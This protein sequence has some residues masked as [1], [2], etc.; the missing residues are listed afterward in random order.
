MTAEHHHPSLG[1]SLFG[2][3]PHRSPAPLATTA[4]IGVLLVCAA[5]VVL[6][7]ISTDQARL[8]HDYLTGAAALRDLYDMDDYANSW[9]WP[10]WAVQIATGLVFLGWLRRARTNA[11]WLAGPDSQHLSRGWTIGGWFCPVVNLWFPHR[12]VADIW[13][14]SAP[15][16]P[17]RATL[18]LPWWLIFVAAAV[19]NI[20]STRER[21]TVRYITVRAEVEQTLRTIATLDTVR[22]GLYGA[23]GLLIILIIARITHWQNTPRDTAEPT[24]HVVR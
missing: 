2:Q 5:Q 10:L 15:H 12:V 6:A 21:I 13:R 22:A 14:A 7:T 18:V 3:E 23:A 16:R 8:V 20:L 19:V 9:N 24:I 1:A 11:E 17:A 4:A